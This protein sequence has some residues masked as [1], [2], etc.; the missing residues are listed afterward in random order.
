MLNARVASSSQDQLSSR[1]QEHILICLNHF[2][3]FFAC[4]HPKGHF[5][6]VQLIS[7]CILNI[8]MKLHSFF[9][10]LPTHARAFTN[11]FISATSNPSHS[12]VRANKVFFPNF[13]TNYVESEI[14]GH[15]PKNNAETKNSL[16]LTGC[17]ATATTATT[18]H[19][20]PSSTKNA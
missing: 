12:A 11:C 15:Q 6:G 5:S 20:E 8:F 10:A 13:L 14:K 18:I 4:E 19:H 9:I 17:L 2:R 16:L 7:N 1:T 3:D